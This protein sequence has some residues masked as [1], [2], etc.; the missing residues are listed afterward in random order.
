M[1]QASDIGQYGI[2]DF[3]FWPGGSAFA[4]PW[5]FGFGGQSPFDFSVGGAIGAITG[6]NIPQSQGAFVPPVVISEIPVVVNPTDPGRE[7]ISKVPNLPDEE[8]LEELLE[9]RRVLE[10][11]IANSPIGTGTLPPIDEDRWGDIIRTPVPVPVDD[12]EFEEEAMAHTWFHSATDAAVAIF[13]DGA[14]G[15]RTPAQTDAWLNA[16][17]ADPVARTAMRTAKK[18][19]RRRRRRLLTDRDFDD[20]NRISTLP[21]NQNVRTVLAKAIGRR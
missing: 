11:I 21:N 19:C 12:E 16:L 2:E 18:G 13:G 6:I 5:D 10:E 1:F 15:A 17:A 3:S 4:N 7:Q 14:A 8:E 9:E 20:L